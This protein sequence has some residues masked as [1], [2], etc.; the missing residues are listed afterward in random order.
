MRPLV[1]GA[2]REVILVSPYFIPGERGL[3]VLCD[4]TRRN[5]RVRV[6]TNSLASTDVPVVHSGYAQYRPR[7]L[8]CGI[9]VHELRRSARRSGSMRPGLSSGASLHAKAVVVDRR[10]VLVGSMNLDPRSRLLNTEIGVLIDSATLGEQIGT[11]F[12]E[13]TDLDQA[14]RVRLATPGDETSPLVWD[15]R[16]DGKAVRYVREPRASW[17]RK[18]LANLFGALAPEE[19]L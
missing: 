13:A 17:W 4:L 14:F 10:S 5:V 15:G 9:E 16:D 2:R 1:E 8:A 11:L 19:L 6:L 3:G 18:L 7:L 12:D